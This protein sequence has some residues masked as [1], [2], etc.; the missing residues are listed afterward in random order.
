MRSARAP[1]LARTAAL[2]AVTVLL[3]LGSPVSTTDGPTAPAG[4]SA[5]TIAQRIAAALAPNHPVPD[6]G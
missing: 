4:H 3:A 6:F 5:H 2:A 1:F